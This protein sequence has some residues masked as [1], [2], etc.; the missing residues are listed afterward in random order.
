MRLRTGK[1]RITAHVY[2]TFF[3]LFHSEKF[4]RAII[5]L[6]WA[7][8]TEGC[9]KSVPDDYNVISGPY[10]WLATFSL[11]LNYD[12]ESGKWS[13]WTSERN[14]CPPV[15]VAASTSRSRVTLCARQIA[16]S[17]R[18]NWF[19]GRHHCTYCFFFDAHQSRRPTVVVLLPSCSHAVLI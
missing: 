2:A 19:T 10:L 1:W 3:F 13:A 5:R 4:E 16:V 9:A 14:P 11:S 18:Q 8:S 6:D 12:V 7:S 17:C 15:T